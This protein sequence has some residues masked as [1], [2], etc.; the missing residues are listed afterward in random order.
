M[1]ARARSVS[2]LAALI[3]LATAVIGTQQ[4]HAQSNGVLPMCPTPATVAEYAPSPAPSGII[5]GGGA[6]NSG[7]FNSPIVQGLAQVPPCASGNY[8]HHPNDDDPDYPITS[9]HRGVTTSVS[10]S[11]VPVTHDPTEVRFDITPVGVPGPLAIGT[12]PE[13]MPVAANTSCPGPAGFS[14]VAVRPGSNDFHFD[15]QWGVVQST[16]QSPVEFKRIGSCPNS[17]A[18]DHAEDYNGTPCSYQLRF[19]GNPDL[20]LP[21]QVI[22]DTEWE[23]GLFSVSGPGGVDTITGYRDEARTVLSMVLVAAGAPNQPAADSDGDGFSDAVDVC[24]DASDLALPRTP[25]TGCPGDV[26]PDGG[27]L[28]TIG[29]DALAGDALANV[30]CGLA[31]ND[32]IR[33]GAG[34]DT[35]FGDGCNVKAKPAAA[36][37]AGGGGNDTLNGDDG[38]DTLYGAGGNDKL[39]GGKGNDK[40]FG[41]KGNDKL[42]GGPGVNRYDGGAGNDTLNARNHKKETVSCGAGKRDKATVDKRDKVKGCEKVRRSK[43]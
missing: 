17:L 15:G 23:A 22:V 31:G 24:P 2:V 35:L 9:I 14:Q 16:D 28:P 11:T 30:I 40:L 36:A 12:L 3:L 1:Q 39:N 32:T 27:G 7:T 41:G 8:A 26:L 20:D 6:G 18:I 37:V 38:N 21:M 4:A 42:T 29:D 5:R 33:G 13:C 43:K 25:R 10:P 34:D 19:L